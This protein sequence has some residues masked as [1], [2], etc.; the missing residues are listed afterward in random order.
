MLVGK[1]ALTLFVMAL[2]LAADPASPRAAEAGGMAA[3]ERYVRAEIRCRGDRLFDA[4]SEA[5]T[6]SPP[7][8]CARTAGNGLVDLLF[9]AAPSTRVTPVSPEARCLS[10]RM[11]ALLDTACMPPP[12]PNVVVV[13]TDDQRWDTTAYMPHVLAD[14]AERGVQFTNGFAST[15][16][17]A[18]SRASILSGRI[19]RHH[20]IRDNDGLLSGTHD[21]DHENTL[22]AWMRAAGYRTALFGKYLNHADVLGETKPAAW[23]EWQSCPYEGANYLDYTLNVNGTWTTFGAAPEDYSTDYLARAAIEFMRAEIAAPFFVVYAPYAPHE[24]A[25][26]APRPGARK[27]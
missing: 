27:S 5:C 1:F 25:I 19:A 21:F 3:L 10:A 18:P 4:D 8:A 24:P 12:P 16:A 9:G 7:P 26:P 11:E 22:A 6:A 14:L 17:C 2:Q 20:G 13:L 23:D 15:P